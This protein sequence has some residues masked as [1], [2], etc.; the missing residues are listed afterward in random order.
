MPLALDAAVDACRT[1]DLWI[2]RGRSRADR[3]IRTL[4]NAPV[5][6]VGMAVVLEDLPPLMWHAELGRKL[7]DVW[8]GT[9]H[10]GVQLHDLGDAVRRWRDEYHQQAWLRQLT[11]E[12]ST[13]AENALLRTIARLDGVSFPSTGRLAWRWLGGRFADLRLP[14]REQ[15]TPSAAFCAEVVAVTYQEMGILPAG[16]PSN[17]YD[18]G[19]FWSGDALELKRGW[20]LGEEIAVG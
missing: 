3:A 2:F 18:P 14:R 6:H 4:T 7:S 8:T 20:Q 13:E 5:N 10:S 9:H 17:W 16:R 19:S 1:G 15:G 12:V 11:P